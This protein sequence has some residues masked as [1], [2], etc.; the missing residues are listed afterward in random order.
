[1]RIISQDGRY[2]LPYEKVAVSMCGELEIVAESIEVH[3][4]FVT[5]AK[6]STKEK[7]DKVMEML[8]DQY[9]H[10]GECRITGHAYRQLGLTFRFPE[11]DEIH[12]VEK[13]EDT[14]NANIT[15]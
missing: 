9:Q 2:D 6:Y 10:F 15:D 5:M 12:T 3:D 14:K 1:M 8:R 11:D 4:W 13:E 7:A